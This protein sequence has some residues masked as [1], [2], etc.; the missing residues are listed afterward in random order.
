M[1]NNVTGKNA[2]IEFSLKNTLWYASFRPVAPLVEVVESGSGN[3]PVDSLAAM[4]AK[5]QR[6]AVNF[7]NDQICWWN[8]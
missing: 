6:F 5:V 4:T 7:I 8:W 1:V 3:D 2:F